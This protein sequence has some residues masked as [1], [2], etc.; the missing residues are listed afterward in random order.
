MSRARWIGRAHGLLLNAVC[1]R[2]W[3]ESVAVDAFDPASLVDELRPA[4]TDAIGAACDREAVASTL[5]DLYRGY[6]GSGSDAVYMIVRACHWTG[7]GTLYVACE[8]AIKEAGPSVVEVLR[9]ALGDDADEELIASLQTG[10]ASPLSNDE[11]LDVL[12]RTL[13]DAIAEEGAASLWEGYQH[14]LDE[15]GE[16]E[17]LGNAEALLKAYEQL[18]RT[19]A[20]TQ[21]L[22]DRVCE[23]CVDIAHAKDDVSYLLPDR[24]QV[25]NACLATMRKAMTP[26]DVR[27][28]L[29]RACQS[30]VPRSGDPWG[31]LSKTYRRLLTRADVNAEPLIADMLV[32]ASCDAV[33]KALSKAWI[34]VRRVGEDQERM[35]DLV[36]KAARSERDAHLGSVQFPSELETLL[37]ALEK[38]AAALDN[39]TAVADLMACFV[40]ETCGKSYGDGI[41]HLMSTLE[42]ALSALKDP[43]AET[44]LLY[45]A[46]VDAILSDNDPGDAVETLVDGTRQA[47][48]TADDPEAAIEVFLDDLSENPAGWPPPTPAWLVPERGQ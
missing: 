15:M 33:E 2:A 30:A 12:L 22:V 35:V 32:R 18:I 20:D 29:L 42:E 48:A 8:R 19:A 4:I 21:W 6:T 5:L 13:R 23:V 14:L 16:F 36:L 40:R 11:A 27:N 45:Q 41:D 28:G 31:V 24:L 17:G 38:S 25:S 37:R 34:A 43:E 47:I 1:K 9:E 26:A 7:S 44:E 10:H 46:Y 3:G 39:P